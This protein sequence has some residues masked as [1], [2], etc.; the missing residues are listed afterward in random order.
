MN[1]P[2]ALDLGETGHCIGRGMT[3][4][5]GPVP[6]VHQVFDDDLEKNR[7]QA[8]LFVAQVNRGGMPRF[9]NRGLFSQGI[10]MRRSFIYK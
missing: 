3:C 2:S 7:R 5:A 8:F 6:F 10:G 1:Q 4:P 9:V